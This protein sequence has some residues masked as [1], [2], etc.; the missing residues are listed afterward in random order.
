[1]F[2]DCGIASAGIHHEFDVATAL[3][4]I[5][6][7][8]EDPPPFTPKNRA[9]L[10]TSGGDILGG[11]REMLMEV[12]GSPTI[13]SGSGEVGL[14]AGTLQ[15][16][17]FGEAPVKITLQYDG[18]DAGDSESLGLVDAMGLADVD[19]T[20]GG[21]NWAL[22]MDF[23]SLDAGDEPMMTLTYDKRK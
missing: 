10:V 3:E 19:L 18:S 7:N 6:F 14:P 1:M 13:F 22:A 16:G 20:D 15:F 11:E 23:V 2:I 8:S 5:T 21:S 4:L 12:V 9:L 17:T